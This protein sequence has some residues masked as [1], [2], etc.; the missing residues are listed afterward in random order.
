MYRESASGL[1]IDAYNDRGIYLILRMFGR[2]QVSD[3]YPTG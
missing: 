1:E 2:K 3:R